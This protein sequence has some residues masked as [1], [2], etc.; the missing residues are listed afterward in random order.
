MEIHEVVSDNEDVLDVLNDLTC[1][2]KEPLNISYI[3]RNYDLSKTVISVHYLKKM[4]DMLASGGYSTVL[5][6]AGEDAP[7]LFSATFQESR[8][9][10]GIAPRL[11][12]NLKHSK[13]EAQEQFGHFDTRCR[14]KGCG[15]NDTY[16]SQ[17]EALDAGREHRYFEG[18]QFKVYSPVGGLVYDSIEGEISQ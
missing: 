7:I 16:E 3:K 15:W 1:D 14:S 5:I 9:F 4:A 13:L 8:T 12:T 17:K 10:G 11:G 6:E 2:R 18:H